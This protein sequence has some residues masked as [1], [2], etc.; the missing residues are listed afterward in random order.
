MLGFRVVLGELP[1]TLPLPPVGP[2]LH[3]QRVVER[4]LDEVKRGPDPEKPYFY[5]PRKYV[6]IARD[7][8]G[9]VF[10]S[11]NHDPAIVECP[12]GDLLAIWYSCVSERNRELGQVASRLRHGTEEWE[13][14][15]LFFDVPDRNDH[16]PAL[17]SDGKGT[18]YHFTGMSFAGEHAHMAFVLRKS[19]DSGATWSPARIPL[20][21][22]TFD[23]MPGEPVLRMKDGGIL[24][25]VDFES[26]SAVWIS[27][28]EGWTWNNPGGV[29]TGIHAGI[30][31]LKDGSILAYG[32]GGEINGMMPLSRSTDRGKTFQTEATEF[33]H[34]D[35]GQRLVLLRLAEGPL[36]FASFA[37]TGLLVTDS[38]GTSREVRGLYGTISTD[39]G[40]TWSHKRLI[41]DDGPGRAV[42]ST[43]GGV[44]TLSAVH[45]EH[46]GYLSV[47]QGAG[48]VIHLIS[49][50]QH[51]AF[52]LKWLRTP[53]APV[54]HPPLAVRK[55][56]ET[57]GGRRGAGMDGFDAD[58]WFEYKGYRGGFDGKGRYGIRSRGR[59]AG[60]NRILGKGSFEMTVSFSD[61]SFRPKG[62]NT[63][64]WAMLRLRDARIRSLSVTVGPA[65]VS[66]QRSDREPPATRPREPGELRASLAAAPQ[67]AKVRLLWDEP[68]RRLRVFY[69]V[70]GEDA[71]HPIPG[72]EEGV[73]FGKPLSE[74]TAL[75]LAFE[76]AS[77]ALEHCEILP[78]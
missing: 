32:R 28:D 6:R 51:Y 64:P 10:A 12:N 2:P 4:S 75:S 70:D 3:Q 76:H 21:D 40:K 58:G 7:S 48:G 63:T 8:E 53:P 16:A 19:T 67:A 78:R 52:N 55:V 41:S 50:R 42:E 74:T 22:Y 24:L 43:S 30:A 1:G 54:K 36:F 18:I 49:S 39:E 17:W 14:A 27:D 35:G 56:V 29:I 72:M 66:V 9:P 61:L 20:P 25:G 68:T 15:S 23:H 45:G 60:L 38:S 47:C 13:P 77:G 71:V 37:D 31:E 11:H 69:G 26:N 46:Q 34:V 44:F 73:E 33:E 62:G 59:A 57:F 5:G 65:A